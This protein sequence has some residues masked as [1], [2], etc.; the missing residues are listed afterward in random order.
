MMPFSRELYIEQEDFMEDPPKKFFRL[1]PGK[2]VRLKHA[3]II[4][5]EAV[6]KNT[7]GE[8]TE[9][10]CTYIPETKTGEANAGMKVKGTLHWVSAPHAVTAEVRL[11]DNLFSEIEPDKIEIPG[12]LNPNS[13]EV[14]TDCKLEPSLKD[15]KPGERFQFLR[16]GYFIADQKDSKPGTPIFNRTTPLRDTWAKVQKKKG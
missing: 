14:L 3:Y 9:L 8:V 15:A 16:M 10:H 5:C 7:A 6:I 4:K 2:E 1:A 13:L 12:S 11:I